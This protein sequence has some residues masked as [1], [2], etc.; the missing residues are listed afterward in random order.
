MKIL[1]LYPP[2]TDPTSG[3][4]SLVYLASFARSRGF[5]DIEIVDTNIEALHYSM[6]PKQV[7]TLKKFIKS[8]R[9]ELERKNYLNGFMQ[10][11]LVELWKSDALDFEGL[12][13][14]VRIMKD[15]VL[16][17]KYEYYRPAAELLSNW[18]NVISVLGYP[19]LM[20]GFSIPT[21]SYFNLMN[22]DDLTNE[23][24]LNKILAPFSPYI[25]DRLVPKLSDHHIKVIGI[26]VT[27]VAQLPFA[28]AIAKIIRNFYP[29]KKYFSEVQKLLVCGSIYLTR[30]SFFVYLIHQMLV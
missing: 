20:E 11:E 8:R 16:F 1:L 25:Y 23:K 18:I 6:L 21:R 5:K 30:T 28:L 26:N 19:G 2:L 27:Y 17:Y 24:I 29:E 10:I 9:K 7:N 15:P 4:H 13:D 3:Y 14:A 22:I 12:L